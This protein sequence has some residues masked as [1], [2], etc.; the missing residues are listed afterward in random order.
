MIEKGQKIPLKK[1]PNTTNTVSLKK[2]KLKL[3]TLVK[4]HT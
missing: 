3:K 2:K 1:I 4:R